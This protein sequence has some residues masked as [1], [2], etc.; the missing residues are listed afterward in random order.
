MVRSK[1]LE[2]V[3]KNSNRK[4][5]PDGPQEKA[6]LLQPKNRHFFKIAKKAPRP[7]TPIIRRKKHPLW[8]PSKRT[9]AL[10]I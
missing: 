4:N 9:E 6:D 10:L 7:I 2:R 5:F 1:M 8:S 3:F